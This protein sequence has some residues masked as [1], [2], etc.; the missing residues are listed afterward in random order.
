MARTALRVQPSRVFLI[1][2]F[3]GKSLLLG[4]LRRCSPEQRKKRRDQALEPSCEHAILGSPA[5]LRSLLNVKLRHP[6]LQHRLQLLQERA[7]ALSGL[8]NANAKSPRFSYAISQIAPL[9]LV[10]AL[11]RNSKSQIAARYPAFWHAISQIALAS[12]LECP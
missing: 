5:L 9:P 2:R 10:A 6:I 4:G 1:K 7:L 8:P 12:F 3:S 11:N